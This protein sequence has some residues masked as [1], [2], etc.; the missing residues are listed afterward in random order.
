VRA[1]IFE[2]FFTTKSAGRGTGLG[3]STVLAI[4]GQS[5]GAI[6]VDSA[7]GKGTEFRIYIPVCAS[8]AD[9]GE[10]APR[11]APLGKGEGIL[12]VEDDPQ[13]RAMARRI[14]ASNGHRVIVA[15][16]SKHAL[17][18]ARGSPSPDLLVTDVI[19]PDGNGVDLA[20]EL[21]RWWP[22][23]PVVFM[24]GYTGQNFPAL[25]ALPA[26]ARFLPKPF[27]PDALLRAVRDALDRRAA[28]L[29][30]ADA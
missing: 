22:G 23:I 5:G 28:A 3:L 7:P 17:E 4:V 24:S 21:G 27:T 13:V 29:V 6:R 9:E 1:Q 15:S 11:P 14:L 19:L 16:G 30:A 18:L 20:R 25:D 12:V 10:G 26:D 2:P 8:G